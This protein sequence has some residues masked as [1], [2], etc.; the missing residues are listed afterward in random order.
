MVTKL[1]T[2][3][4]ILDLEK[5]AKTGKYTWKDLKQ[6]ALSI[7]VSE[8]TAKKYLKEVEARLRKAGLIK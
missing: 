6:I 4:R 1:I 7:P 8:P 3:S 2:H 5:K